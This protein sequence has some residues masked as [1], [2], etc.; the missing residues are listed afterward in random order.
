MDQREKG[1]IVEAHKGMGQGECQINVT[2][3]FQ[4]GSGCSG[5]LVI[6]Q[7]GAVLLFYK[8][9]GCKA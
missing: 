4:V 2:L 3:G 9:S 8:Q 1:L 7:K 6:N 5:E